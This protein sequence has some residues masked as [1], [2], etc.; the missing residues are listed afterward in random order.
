MNNIYIPGVYCTRSD[1]APAQLIS[2]VTVNIEKLIQFAKDHPDL[3]TN[4]NVRFTI[5][6]DENGIFTAK[7]QVKK[8]HPGYFNP[9]SYEH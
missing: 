7:V 6:A 3:I 1:Y 2:H 4:D 8:E 9:Q 5:W